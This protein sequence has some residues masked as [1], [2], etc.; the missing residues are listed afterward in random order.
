[1]MVRSDRRKA[2]EAEIDA[3]E[4][5]DPKVVFA[6]AYDDVDRLARNGDEHA[7]RMLIRVRNMLNGS[8]PP[9]DDPPIV[10]GEDS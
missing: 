9:E 5:L 6:Y 7:K 10:A 8:Y 2:L 1:M 4:K 3:V